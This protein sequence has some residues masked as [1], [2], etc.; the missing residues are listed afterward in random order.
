MTTRPAVQKILKRIQHTE[1]E[2]EHNHENMQKINF[3]R[4]IDNKM[5]IR[6]ESNVIKNKKL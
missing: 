6:K 3:T 1:E 2:G 5:I 4:R